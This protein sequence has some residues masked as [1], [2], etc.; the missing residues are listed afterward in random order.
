MSAS[1]GVIDFLKPDDKKKIET[2]FSKLNKDS[3]FEFMFFNYKKDNQNFMPMK[4]YLHVLEYLSTRNKLD[5]TVSLEKSINLDIN[6]VSDDMKTNYR[7]TIDGIENIN[8]NIKLVSNRN[9]HLIFKVLLSKMLKGDKNI[10]LIKK[11]KNFDNIHDVDNLNF[12]CRMSSE[13]KVSDS[14][15]DKLK[16]LSESSRSQ[17]TF[18]F[19]QRVTLFVKKSTDT[20]LRIDLTNVK[21]NNNINKI[22][23]GN[24]SYELEIDLSSNSARKELLTTLYREVGVL[25]KILQRSNFIIDLDTQKRV[26]N[27]YQNLMSIPNDKMVSLDGRRV[28]TLEVQHVVDKLPNKYAVTDKADG[29]RTFIMIS[30]NHLY[31]ITDVL[32]VQDMGIEIS[33]KLSKYNGTIIDGEY[34]FLP[35]YNRHLFMAFDCLFKG[36][37]DIRN[38]SSFMKRISHLDEVIDNCFVL[39]KQKG[40]KFNEYNGKFDISL[41]MKHHEKELESHLKD[42]NHDVTIDRKFPLIRRKYFMG[43]LGIEDNEIFKYSKLLWEKYLY[44]SKN[45]LYMLDGLIYNPLDQKYVVSVKDSK[46]LDYKWKPPTQNSI[47][48]YIEFERDRETGEILTLYDNS[49]EELIKGKPYRI[50]NLY[51]GK[52]IRGEEK[53]VLFQ[54]KEKKYIANLNLVD[55]QIRD[56]EGKLIEDKTVV[57]FYYNTDPNISEYFRWTPLRTRFDK[58]ESIRRFG[59]KYGNYFDTANKIWRNIINPLLFNDIVILSKDDTFKKHLSVLRNKIDHSVIVSEYKENVYYQM[60]TSLAKPMRN[61]HNWIKSIVIYT[62]CNPEYTQG[63]QLE[64]LDFACGRGGDIMKFYYAKVKL[65]VGLDIDLNGIESQTDGALSRYRQLSKT[66]P[67]FP[68][69]VFIHADATTPLNNEAQNK[70]LGYRSKNSMKLMDEFFSKDQS[71]RKMFDRVNCQFAIHYFLES[72][73]KWNNFTTNLKNH[74]KPGGYFLTSCFD[75]S[76]IIETLGEK[77]SFSTFYTNNKGEKKKLFEINKKFGEIDTKKPIGLGNPIDVHNAFISHE[78]VYLTEYLVDKRFLVKE[79]LEKCDLELVETDLFDNQFEIHREYFENYVK[80]E[81]NPQTRKFLNNAAEFYNQ[82]D[83]VNKASFTITMM[84]RFYIFRRKSN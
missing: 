65:L 39:G 51:V 41:I 10:T 40:H 76:R 15:I 80:F 38:E 33:S 7:L 55:N 2:I 22:T 75:A 67:G 56:I 4:K 60:K 35:K 58:T 66:H 30:N 21:M 74:L 68:R 27:D 26:L 54:E 23:K 1:K 63:R 71:K 44:D 34:I 45:T 52:K 24:P 57:E 19:K 81:H 83:S 14:E 36:G 13:T 32:E 31:M 64:V 78:G 73:T 48:F 77:D 37:E 11:E 53:P 42:L 3:E 49:R 79:L 5:K 12:R 6:Y 69:M 47:D 16:K 29:D 61:F 18:R 82:N 72:E 62:N 43:A 59:K 28:Y 84:N 9:N 20:T 50:C 25:L 46:F 8:N 17:V 70:A